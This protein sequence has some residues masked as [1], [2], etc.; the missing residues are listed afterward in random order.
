MDFLR[1]VFAARMK[2]GHIT[3]ITFDRKRPELLL[4]N[5]VGKVW[6]YWMP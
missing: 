2:H 6:N 3:V 5:D 1:I 4:T